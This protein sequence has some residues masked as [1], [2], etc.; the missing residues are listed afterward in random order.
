MPVQPYIP[1]PISPLD[2][3]LKAAQISQGAQRIG[4]QG[5]QLEQGQQRLNLYEQSL[6]QSW[7]QAKKKAEDRRVD[8]NFKLLGVLSKI[9]ATPEQMQNVWNRLITDF[10]DPSYNNPL[11]DIDFTQPNSLKQA[12]DI[13]NQYRKESTAF[14][15]KTPDAQA[16]QTAMGAWGAVGDITPADVTALK[17]LQGVFPEA[18]KALTTFEQAGVAAVGRGAALPG[19]PTVEELVAGKERLTPRLTPLQQAKEARAQ[20]GEKREVTRLSL[21]E[22]REARQVKKDAQ[23]KILPKDLRTRSRRAKMTDRALAADFMF[24]HSSKGFIL[25]KE[26][27]LE[28]VE[29]YRTAEGKRPLTAEQGEPGFW[30]RLSDSW[31]VLT[32]ESS[33]VPQETVQPG[34]PQQEFALPPGLTK[35]DLQYNMETYGKSREEV[36]QAFQARQGR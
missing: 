7:K 17:G 19:E 27:A 13:Y 26:D 11:K 4:L 36:I 31:D 6:N 14:G 8:D 29:N 5:Q 28:M 18:P 22:K 33:V 24:E 34:Q 35:E 23:E 15:G 30:Q 25:S 32:G 20:R 21:A 1:D 3:A 2:S 10:D 12:V 9:K 16:R